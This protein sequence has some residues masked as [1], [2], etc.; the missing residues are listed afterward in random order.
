MTT[1]GGCRAY[2]SN[3][4]TFGVLQ[5]IYLPPHAVS[6]P[7]TEVPMEA[8]IGVQIKSKSTPLQRDYSCRKYHHSLPSLPNLS[9]FY[10]LL[11]FNWNAPP[12]RW[13][14]GRLLIKNLQKFK[15]IAAELR[16]IG[17]CDVVDSELSIRRLGLTPN[18]SE[19][20]FHLSPI[21]PPK[22][23]KESID[24]GCQHEAIVDDTNRIEHCDSDTTR[25]II[26]DLTCQ[27]ING[28]NYRR[29][30]LTV[31]ASSS[32]TLS[33]I[34]G[35][36]RT[37]ESD[38][39]PLSEAK[40]YHSAKRRQRKESLIGRS[41]SFQEQ[42]VKPAVRNSRFFI[43]R[44]EPPEHQVHL[45]LTNDETVSHHNIE[46]TV[47]DMDPDDGADETQRPHPVQKIAP[48][49]NRPIDSTS[50]D[51]YEIKYERSKL[52]SGHLFGRLMRRMRKISHGWRKSG[53]KIRGRGEYTCSA[54]G[55]G[56]TANA[57]KTNTSHISRRLTKFV[58]TKKT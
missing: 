42:D 43:R 3:E 15:N 38:A 40:K 14:G 6:I 9:L 57:L 4:C 16:T 52:R 54:T 13:W 24:S 39:N 37:L 2:I 44:H 11:W 21:V 49:T 19:F 47:E 25:I 5:P 34:S 35:S 58:V 7:R 53:C 30:D 17:F 41:R 50:L 46:I 8:I 56:N 22:Y 29:H 26:D 45:N 36:N 31:N 27:N 1:H 20:S 33:D 48:R 10:F 51:S 28:R 32:S 55:C 12:V 18:D 23:S